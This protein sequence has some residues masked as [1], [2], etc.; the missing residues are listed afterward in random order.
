MEALQIV[1]SRNIGIKLIESRVVDCLS[2]VKQVG[3]APLLSGK[4]K[5]GRSLCVKARLYKEDKNAQNREKEEGILLGTERDGSG[6]VVGFNLIPHSGEN[7]DAA[8]R[9]LFEFL[10]SLCLLIHVCVFFLLLMH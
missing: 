8:M 1:P 9:N 5:G 7:S 10:L 2:G 3:L 4:K 6:S